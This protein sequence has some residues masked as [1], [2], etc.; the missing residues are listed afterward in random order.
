MLAERWRAHGAGEEGLLKTPPGAGRFVVAAV[1]VSALLGTPQVALAS[2]AR[3]GQLR[4]VVT[5]SVSLSTEPLG[6]KIS[7][8]RAGQRVSLTVTST[9]SRGFQWKSLS[10][11]IAGPAGTVSPA[12][13]PSNGPSYTGLDAMGPFDFMASY[14]KSEPA[15]FWDGNEPLAFQF[16]ATSGTKTASVSVHRSLGASVTETSEALAKQGFVGKYWAP[17]VMSRKKHPAVLLFGGSEGGLVGALLPATLA[18]HGYPTLDVAYFKEPGL[19]QS[20]ADIP[21]EYFVKAL[22]WLASRPGVDG[23]RLWVVGGSRG[24][25]AALLLGVHYPGLV[26]GVAALVPSD[27]AICSYPGCAGPAWTF[28][29]NAVPYTRQFDDPH[30]TDDPAA[31]IPVARIK[32]PVFLD[33]GGDDHVWSSCPYAHAIMAELGAAHD[34]YPHTLI[35]SQGGGHG[36]ALEVPYEPGTAEAEWGTSLAGGTA[37]ANDLAWATQWPRFMD[38]LNN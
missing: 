28:Q 33:C 20:L 7:G 8:L 34:P 27:V 16:E 9:D 11:Y 2:P 19:P 14:S 10:T 21:L 5:P 24:S 22:R 15:Y 29:G 32:G 26:H 38:F 17:M 12:S 30:P 37:V 23:H 4:L 25:E 18:A 13:S 1:A 36:S 6:I 31:V 35:V 3:Q